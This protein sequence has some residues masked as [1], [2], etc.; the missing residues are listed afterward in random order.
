M[1]NTQSSSASSTEDTPPDIVLLRRDCGD[2]QVC[3]VALRIEDAELQKPAGVV[4]RFLNHGCSIYQ[5]RPSTCRHWLC[6]WRMQPELGED[7]RPDRSGVLLIPEIAATPGFAAR[8][9]TMQFVSPALLS[10]PE[11]LNKLCGF[12]AGHAP[13]YLALA[14]RQTKVLA[15]PV[16][17]PFI[18]AGDGPAIL[19]A[20]SGLLRDLNSP[21]QNR[22]AAPETSAGEVNASSR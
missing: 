16:L 8:G 13:L 6:G 11:I 20:I 15:N 2:C 14:G 12:I 1:R 3:C 9:Y 10:S 17:A 4:C 7:W 18:A 5:S 22:V 19:A 21:V